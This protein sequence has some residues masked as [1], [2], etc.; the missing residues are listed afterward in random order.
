MLPLVQGAEREKIAQIVD[1]VDGGAAES[2]DIY[3]CPAA[4][5][6]SSTT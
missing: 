2:G 6:Q 5:R 3:P 4:G 1:G